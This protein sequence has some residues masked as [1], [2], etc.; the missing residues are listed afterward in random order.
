MKEYNTYI[1]LDVHKDK[2]SVA[3]AGRGMEKPTYHAAIGSDTK[4]VDRLLRRYEPGEVKFCYEAGPTGYGLY[5]YLIRKGYACDVVAPSLIPKK[6]GDRV[7]TDRRDAEKLASLLRA[8]ELTPIYVLDEEHES[9]RDLTRAREDA[10][11]AEKKAKVT[12]GAFL[13]RHGKIYVGKTTWSKGYVTWLRTLTFPYSHQQVVFDDYVDTVKRCME[14]VE[15]LNKQVQA[16]FETWGLRPVCEA[17]MA[18]RGISLITAMTLLAE[19]GDLRR[20]SRAR[21]LMAYLGLV[22]TESTTGNSV[23]RGSITKAG[24]SHVRRVLVE[25][26]WTYRLPP[27]KTRHWNQRAKGVPDTVQTISYLAMI[28]LHQRYWRLSNRGLKTQKV[29]VAIARELAGFIWA[30]A[31]ECYRLQEEIKKA[32]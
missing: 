32:A 23:Q 31:Q 5:R 6:A 18:F 3:D 22:P 4:A 9:V 24:N 17:L 26:A 12:L 29:A 15:L 14:R 27:R 19:L 7:K 10:K 25:S 1:G 21:E 28:R 11:E 13:L 30:G 2:I 20:F 16:V 8:G